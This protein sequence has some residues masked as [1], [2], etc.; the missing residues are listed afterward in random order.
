MEI[1]AIF[2]YVAALASGHGF[3]ES[4]FI[5][6]AAG[7]IWWLG[8]KIAAIVRAPD[9]YP[10]YIAKRECP[11]CHGELEV[12]SHEAHVEYDDI[13]FTCKNCG[14]IYTVEATLKEES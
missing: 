3:V 2:A 4:I 12:T 9:L 8:G 1:V 14:E 7:L 13:I 10:Y 5:G 6:I 11:D